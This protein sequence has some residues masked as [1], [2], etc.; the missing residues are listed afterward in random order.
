MSAS[1]ANPY[2]KTKVMTASPG[3]LRQLLLDGAVKF[4]RQARTGLENTD[5]EAVY[6][7]V[8]RCQSILLELINALRPEE[9]PD[10][11]QRL[12]ALYTYLY[13]QLMNASSQRDSA[14]LDEVIQLL[15]YESETWTMVMDRL[16]HENHRAAASS[17]DVSPSRHEHANLNDPPTP[18][19]DDPTL[20]GATSARSVDPSSVGSRASISVQG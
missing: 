7:G 1:T 4:A 16:R 18:G 8:T 5:Y 14:I 20:N 12:S 3:E 13:R 6:N 10:L 9:N 19:K 11:C 15:E 2:L 17:D